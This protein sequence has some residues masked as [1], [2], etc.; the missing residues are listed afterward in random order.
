MRPRR[1]HLAKRNIFTSQARKSTVSGDT[2]DVT[3]N[4]YMTRNGPQKAICRCLDFDSTKDLDHGVDQFDPTY[5][6]YKQML[7]VTR[8]ST[9]YSTNMEPPNAPRKESR[10]LT[11][12]QTT[13][14][15][16]FLWFSNV[17][18]PGVW[19]VHAIL[20]L[21]CLSSSKQ[22]LP[23]PSKH[24]TQPQPVSCHWNSRSSSLPILN[25]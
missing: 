23:K 3:G 7:P 1:T 6:S 24:N 4:L 18:F 14:L 2:D 22:N 15:Y 5:Q 25:S 21:F 19:S 12:T 20:C 16:Q 11:S 10:R 8:I 13:N 9:P 17:R